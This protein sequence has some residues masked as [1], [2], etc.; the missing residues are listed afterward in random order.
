MKVERHKIQLNETSEESAGVRELVC[1]EDSKTGKRYLVVIR[2]VD[3]RP[4]CTPVENGIARFTER[5]DAPLESHN[6]RLHTPEYYRKCEQGDQLEGV[7]ETDLAPFIASHMR[8]SGIPANTASVTANAQLA[9]HRKVWILCTSIKPSNFTDARS[10]ER[11][12]SG[13]GRDARIFTV[14]DLDGFA[15]QLGISVAQYAALKPNSADD[16]LARLQRLYSMHVCGTAKEIDAFVQVTH[17]PV[18][19]G[20]EGLII[21]RGSDFSIVELDKVLFTKNPKFSS[22]QEYRFSVSAAC[23]ACDFIQIDI[24]P[25]LSELIRQ[26]EYGNRWWSS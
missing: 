24:S 8:S 20:K 17:G 4:T 23:P 22:E 12:F 13:K 18:H 25:E 11:Y 16:F 19:Y 26:W 3:L 1:I 10:L 9:A 21:Q 7:Q 5:K 15:L 14:H 6:I 2:H